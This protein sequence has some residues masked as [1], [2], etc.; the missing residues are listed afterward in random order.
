MTKRAAVYTRV[1][2]DEQ[3]KGYSLNTQVDACLQYAAGRGYE[4]VETY[5]EDYSG[6]ILDRPELDRLRDII[7]SGQIDV[8]IV[9][10]IDRLARKSAYQVL[11]EEEFFRSNV[12]VEYVIGQYDDSDEGRLQKQIRATIAEYEKAKILERSKRGKRGK[13][14]S[15]FVIVG[16]RPPYGYQVRSEPH[17]AWLELD[18][19]EA[20][21]VKLVFQWYLDGDGQ[22]GP[23]SMLSITAKLTAMGIPTRGD[24]QTHVA[25]KRDRCVWSGGMIRHILS[26]EAYTGIWHYGKTRMITDGKELQRKS[27]PKC[28]FGKQVA[29]PKEEWIAVSVPAII[30]PIDFQRARAIMEKNIEQSK[31][32]V[33]QKFLLGRRL[34]CGKCGYSYIGKSRKGKH[35]YYFCKGREQKPVCLCDMPIFRCDLIDNTVWEWVR[36]LI[37]EPDAF[38][39]GLRGL[40]EETRRKNHAL[41]DRLELIESQL[42]ETEKQQGKLLDLYL[43][44]DFPKEVLLERKS[45]LQAL[46]ID[47]RKEQTQLATFLQKITYSDADI[48]TIEDFCNKLRNKLDTATFEGKRRILDMLDVRGKLAIEN[49]EKVIYVSCLISPQPVSLALTSP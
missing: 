38:A 23:L 6:A 32:Q 16:A 42:A 33:R 49:D 7:S 1:S 11:I 14:K 29:R 46:V 35:L 25:K 4:V 3:A 30:D 8:V 41:F 39:D 27:K 43:S 18:E 47:L 20:K 13:A 26:N 19:E 36:G 40:Q 22:N 5:K 9:Y 24:K 31:R 10:D 28:G 15:G 37:E 44:G 45:R 12:S 2:T 34:K 21:I 48:V 17:K